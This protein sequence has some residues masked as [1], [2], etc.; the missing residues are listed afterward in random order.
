M[1]SP[2]DLIDNIYNKLILKYKGNDSIIEKIN[3]SKDLSIT[4]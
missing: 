1:N 3:Q 4:L 2:C